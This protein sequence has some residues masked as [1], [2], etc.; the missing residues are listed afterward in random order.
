MKR[1]ES[2][3]E[4][5]AL[6]EQKPYVLEGAA[7]VHIAQSI[8]YSLSGFPESKSPFFQKWIGSRVARLFLAIGRMKHD[9]HAPVPGAPSI[10]EM[11]YEEGLRRVRDAV[12]S[13]GRSRGPFAPHF[14]YGPLSKADYERLQAY[15]VVDHLRSLS[16]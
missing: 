4:A 2:L 8:E 7:L 5:L 3:A 12:A 11:S 1:V 6:L 9:V 14:A 10:G 13:F 16:K 15:H